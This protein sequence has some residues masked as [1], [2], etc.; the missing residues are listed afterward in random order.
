[1]ATRNPKSKQVTEEEVRIAR[2]EAR[3]AKAE[4]V[5]EAIKKENFVVADILQKE[6]KRSPYAPFTTSTLQQE[7]SRRFGYSGKRTMSFAQKLYEEGFITYHR[8]IICC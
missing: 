5:V 7:A 4:A 1:M 6:T 8:T 3:K 2:L